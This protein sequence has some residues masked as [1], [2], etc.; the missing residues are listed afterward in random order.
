MKEYTE[1]SEENV[2]NLFTFFKLCYESPTNK[3]DLRLH[4][5]FL[6][7]EHIRNTIKTFKEA[8][9]VDI[10]IVGAGKDFPFKYKRTILCDYDLSS[11]SDSSSED[12]ID[13][14]MNVKEFRS[15][16]RI[17]APNNLTSSYT[18]K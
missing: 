1:F 8:M 14:V 18:G 2:K 7:L 17:I 4:P 11:S 3:A 15:S 6:K 5:S 12:S 10:F 9:G 13:D 16:S